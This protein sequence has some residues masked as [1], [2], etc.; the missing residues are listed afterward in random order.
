MPGTSRPSFALPAFAILASAVLT[1]LACAAAYAQPVP[2]GLPAPG[3]AVQTSNGPAMVTGSIGGSAAIVAL[4]GVAAN[5]ILRDNG[6]GSST[7]LVPG[8]PPQVVFTPR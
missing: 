3:T 4:P 6:N 1:A 5:G 2:S 7:I 8:G